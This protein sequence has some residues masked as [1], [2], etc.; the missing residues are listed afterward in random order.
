MAGTVQRILAIMLKEVRQLARDRP[1][2]GMIIG[3]PLL[4]IL[5]FGYAINFDVRQLRAAYVDDAQ[6]SYSRA[7]LGDMQASDVVRFLAPSPGVADLRRRLDAG[8]IS[9]GVVIPSDFERRRLGG[10]RPVAQLLIDG[11]EPMADGVARSLAN[12]PL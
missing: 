11:S 7:L 2:F 1:T 6:T 10:E 5:L 8:E 12:T 3:I 4:Q 9:V